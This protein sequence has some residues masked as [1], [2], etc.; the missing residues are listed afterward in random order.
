MAVNMP[1][2]VAV[3]EEVEGPASLLLQ[4]I[5]A[6]AT[7]KAKSIFFIRGILMVNANLNLIRRFCTK[8]IRQRKVA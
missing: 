8:K 4:A 2:M 5:K 3:G 7:S 1:S 6:V